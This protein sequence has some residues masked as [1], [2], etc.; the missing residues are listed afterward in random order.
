[1][2]PQ[3]SP[4]L[5]ELR[6]SP[7]A[8]RQRHSEHRLAFGLLD[9]SKQLRNPVLSAKLRSFTISWARYGYHG[10][11]FE[12]DSIED[13]LAQAAAGDYGFCLIQAYGHVIIE[14]WTPANWNGK[15]FHQSL[16][17]L[18]ECNNFLLTS[19]NTPEIS[20]SIPPCLLVNLVQWD[21]A[22][23][24]PLKPVAGGCSSQ[25]CA[26]F[27]QEMADRTLFLGPDATQDAG[28][29]VAY[30]DHA[31]ARFDLDH[32]PDSLSADQQ[33]FLSVA[34]A[35]TRGARRGVFLW[36]VESY[37]DVA[38]PNPAL[39]GPIGTLACVA[40]GFKPNMILNTHGFDSDTRIVFFDYSSQALA[41]R[42]LLHEEWD[43][44]DYPR[45]LEYVFRKLPSP[46]TFYHLWNDKR[47]EELRA[48]DFQQ[49]W[50]SEISRWGSAQA[51]KDHWREYRRLKH[52]FVHCDVLSEPH[53]LFERLGTGPRDVIWWSNAFFTV[54]SNWFLTVPERK[55][56]YDA[57][58]S[59]LVDR[60]RKL[61]LYGFD[62]NNTGVNNIQAGHYAER[63]F[64]HGGNYLKPDRSRLQIN[65]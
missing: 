28:Q 56:I 53:K 61:F 32:S 49:G 45:F 50:E 60:N 35:H 9:T 22:G 31:I 63:Y 17:N 29:F 59:G 27:P 14:P 54:F 48:E 16:A 30:L 43:G 38:E 3:S 18:I 41:F 2:M 65:C 23:R 19:S 62:Y 51:I 64:R 46:E 11:I 52:E 39:C 37:R 33:R 36:N 57:W 13:I 4:G 1:M 24:P 34:R 47:P 6:S 15:N 25:I 10:P 8:V 5:G 7:Q 40:A 21:E 44:E 42:K 26:T 58:I 12:G 55:V 20:R